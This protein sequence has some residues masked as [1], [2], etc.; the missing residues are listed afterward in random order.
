MMGDKEQWNSSSGMEG[1]AEKLC[2]QC[3]GVNS[4]TSVMAVIDS[5]GF[6]DDGTQEVSIH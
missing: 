4:F 3:G 6:K 1:S 5:W 2:S